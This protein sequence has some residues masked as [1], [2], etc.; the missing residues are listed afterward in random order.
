MARVEGSI[1]RRFRGVASGESFGRVRRFDESE[2]GGERLLNRLGFLTGAADNRARQQ[3]GALTS[4]TAAL[5][6]ELRR[7]GAKLG[8][9][10][11]A[12]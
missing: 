7:L 5:S 11:E 10:T 3:T 4:A 9:M 1:G 2:V 6:P 12:E 8:Q